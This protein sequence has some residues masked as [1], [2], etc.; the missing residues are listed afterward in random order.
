VDEQTAKFSRKTSL[1]EK[2]KNDVNQ[3]MEAKTKS[4]S[5]ALPVPDLSSR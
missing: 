4:K 2:H 1:A 5:V 3:K